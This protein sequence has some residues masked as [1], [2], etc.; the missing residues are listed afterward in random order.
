MPKKT[1]WSSWTSRV[2]SIC[3]QNLSLP[4]DHSR[5]TQQQLCK[6][7]VQTTMFY[8]PNSSKNSEFGEWLSIIPIAILQYTRPDRQNLQDQKDKQDSNLHRCRS[9][10]ISISNETFPSKILQGFLLTRDENRKL[11]LQAALYWPSR[12]QRRNR[13]IQHGCCSDGSWLE[14]S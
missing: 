8:F 4:A 12:R 6:Q 13:G 14:F 5:E 10:E 9:A 2:W 7:D 1:L 3:S 11:L